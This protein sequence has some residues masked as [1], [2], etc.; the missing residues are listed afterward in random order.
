MLNTPMQAGAELRNQAEPFAGSLGSACLLCVHR[1]SIATNPQQPQP[2][3]VAN[4]LRFPLLTEPET[5][6][7]RSSSP[8]AHAQST[9]TLYT[10]H[11]HTYPSKHVPLW[12]SSTLL[13]GGAGQQTEQG[14]KGPLGSLSPLYQQ[15]PSPVVNP[16]RFTTHQTTSTRHTLRPACFAYRAHSTSPQTLLPR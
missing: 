13:Q 8:H 1:A 7:R 4:C 6:P 10:L 16:D 2:A 15:R 12:P 3:Q 9:S 14:P 5:R 11:R